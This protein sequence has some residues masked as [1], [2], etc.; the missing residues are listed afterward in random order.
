MKFGEMVTHKFFE[1][2]HQKTEVNRNLRS[3]MIS[4]FAPLACQL[5][6]AQNKVFDLRP[7]TADLATV[8]KFPS[9]T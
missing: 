9:S 7:P 6:A 2:F 3:F 4:I 5:E 8:V 1:K